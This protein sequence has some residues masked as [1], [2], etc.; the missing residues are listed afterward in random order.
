MK[1][2]FTITFWRSDYLIVVVKWG[3]AHGAKGIAKLGSIS[4]S[5]PLSP[6]RI[7]RDEDECTKSI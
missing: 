3:N 1:E 6:K 7:K 2:I 5:P 4:I